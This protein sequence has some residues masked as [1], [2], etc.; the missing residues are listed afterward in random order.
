MPME[1]FYRFV[2]Q[3]KQFFSGEITNK[4]QPCSRIYYFTVH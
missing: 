4:M 2:S 3:N 1:Y